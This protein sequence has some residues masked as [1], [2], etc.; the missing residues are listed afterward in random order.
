MYA[1]VHDLR[2][3]SVEV[4]R[5][6]D[7]RLTT[8]LLEASGLIDRVTGS[9]FE[10][11]AVELRLSGRDAPSIYPPHPPV[12]LTELWVWDEQLDLDI[13]EVVGAPVMSWSDGPRITRRHGVFSR[14]NGNVRA[15]G[16]WGDVERDVAGAWQTPLP[17]RR[18]A[19]LLALRWVGPLADET[20][21]RAPWR[22]V[23]EAT[24]DQSVRYSDGGVGERPLTSDPEVDALL[25]PFVRRSQIGAA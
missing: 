24:R 22:V 19:M 7:E 14:G 6:S 5:A 13:V 18:A 20:E 11:R 2:F 3:E 9:F 10:P 23:A 12:A 4:E 15:I 16:T 21:R 1:T 17:I 25:W 8:L